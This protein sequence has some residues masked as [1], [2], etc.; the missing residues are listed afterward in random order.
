VFYRV[1]KDVPNNWLL[2]PIDECVSVLMLVELHDTCGLASSELTETGDDC[3]SIL[4]KKAYKKMHI[5]IA[6]PTQL[7]I[8]YLMKGIAR[9]EHKLIF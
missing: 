2:R 9:R 7:I 4:A 8:I 1:F 5:S 6:H 3:Q